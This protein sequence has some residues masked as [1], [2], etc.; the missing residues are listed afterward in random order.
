M[1]ERVR[2]WVFAASL[3]VLTVTTAA[4]QSTGDTADTTKA[5]A[6]DRLLSVLEDAEARQLLIDRLTATD[7]AAPQDEP[8]S[9]AQA[10]AQDSAGIAQ[11]GWANIRSIALDFRRLFQA[12]LDVITTPVSVSPEVISLG[13]TILASLML[14]WASSLGVAAVARRLNPVIAASWHRVWRAVAIT[15]ILRLIGVGMTW[16][17]GYLLAFFV[18]GQGD[19]IATSQVLFLNAYLVLGACLVVLHI[20]FSTDADRE[21][22]GTRLAAGAQAVILRRMRTILA[23]VIL[24]YLFMLPL[25]QQWGAAGVVGP[26]RSA[27]ATVA[28]G[29]AL[30]GIVRIVRVMRIARAG[31]P[32]AHDQVDADG[33][34][35]LVRGVQVVIRRVLPYLA[36]FYVLFLWQVAVRRPDDLGD[37][38]LEGTLYSVVAVG[39]VT[40]ALRLIDRA[41]TLRAPLPA[42]LG[43]SLVHF[44]PRADRIM[45]GVGYVVATAMIAAS[46]ALVVVGWGWIDAATLF[47]D[48][49]GAAL[50]SIASAVLVAVLAALVWSMLAAWIDTR[51][52]RQGNAPVS[53]RSRTL[54]AL[55]RNAVAIV[56]AVFS[57]MII[58]SQIGIDVAPLLAGAGVVGLAIGF[59]AQKLVQDIINGVFIQLENAINEGDVVG[60]AG[61]TGG[62][63]KVT[64]RSVTLRTLDGAAHIV[65]F[66]SV[67]TVTN[68]TRDFSF[69]VAEI[70]VAY[71]EK[72][73]RVKDAMREAFETVRA[74]FPATA[75]LDD[76]DM[77]GVIALADSAVVVR[78]RI[79]TQPGKQWAIGRRY[80][81]VVKEVL[82]A[83]GIEIPFPHTQIV[84]PHPLIDPS[85]AEAL[86]TT[87]RRRTG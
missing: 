31:W 45:V 75:I 56:F 34:R 53:A 2:L 17:G 40:L 61:I 84:L 23:L 25:A 5:D 85:E 35:S 11:D 68:M 7:A 24:G 74:E 86:A 78:A 51:L 3:A 59:G 60:V 42:S 49:G 81:E 50:W 76:L 41:P 36:A 44:S 58:L 12:G 26:L 28:A 70:G 20:L 8:I 14:S 22:T 87:A 46:V 9:L 6:V 29:L 21:A 15:T 57:V 19:G 38:V 13:L 80:T 27:I 83:R 16:F 43:Q 37:I 77:Q 48:R 52:T 73:P 54:L 10:L 55:L 82:D 66:S 30:Y 4:A 33:G 67:D 71:K 39:L 32:V 69:H 63:E 47:A 64:L 18:F 72:V 65:P 79:K 1:L 62:V